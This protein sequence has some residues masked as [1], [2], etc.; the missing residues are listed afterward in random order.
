[1]SVDAAGGRWSGAI[2][3][4]RTA[5]LVLTGALLYLP[6]LGLRV[7]E[8][9]D[10][11]DI[12]EVCR[13]MFLSG[14]WIAPRRMG[15]IWVDY[16]P[17]IYWAGALASHVL[18]GMSAFALRLP[19]AVAAVALALVTARVAARC[20]GEAAGAWAGFTLLTFQ[21][22]LLQGVGYRP[23]VLFS[24]WI[25]CGMFAYAAG[26]A[27][28][29]RFVLRLAGFAMFGLAMLAKGPLGLLLPGLVLVLWHGT[30]REWRRVLELA[31]LS[32]VSLAVYLPWFVA[33]ARAMGAQDILHELYAQNFQ[34]FH[35][36]S[37][38]HGQP[39]YYYL[40]YFWLDFAP[41]SPLVPAALAWI[42]RTRRWRDRHVQLAVWWFGAFFVFLSLAVTKRHLY[43]LPAYPALA[44]LLAPWLAAVGRPA[45]AADDAPSPRPARI[46]GGVLALG[47]LVG[48]VALGVVALAA[49]TIVARLPPTPEQLA[50]A[51]AVRLP[52]GLTALVSFGAA[53]WL[54]QAWRRRTAGTTLW[55]IGAVHVAL[56]VVLLAAVMP[57]LNPLKTYVPQSRWIRQQIGDETHFGMVA[58]RFGV[59]KRGA[60]AYYTGAMVDLLQDREQVERWFGEH[61]SSLV[62]VHEEAIDRIVGDDPRWRACVVRELRAGSHRYLALRAPDPATAGAAAARP[63]S[64][65]YNRPPP[66]AACATA[67]LQAENVAMLKKRFFKTKAECEVSFELDSSDAEQVELLCEANG[68][69]PIPMKK[70][71]TGKFRTRM[72]LPKEQRFQFRYLVDGRAWVNDE[73]ADDFLP[74]GFG[75]QNGVLDTAPTS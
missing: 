38:G 72:R 29:S 26:A 31:P 73:N 54:A 43:L 60:F 8:Y 39:P 40:A 22:F 63:G 64:F 34:R 16:P 51:R 69:Q 47:F 58:P 9:P 5:F 28:R 74:N 53:L 42:V 35:S 49:G 7:L 59:R 30:R 37:R 57:A 12:A 19:N 67:F 10:E 32:L 27:E 23:D 3:R 17:M 2:A 52:L 61:P 11:L 66:A 62:L 56:Y 71:K 50:A 1:M 21:G 55:R 15:V 14:D 18:G 25:G 46:Y 36:G 33:C 4:H 44:L 6:F 48:A 24:L 68:W 65:R 70:A 13:A 45:A 41:W 20:W 75:G